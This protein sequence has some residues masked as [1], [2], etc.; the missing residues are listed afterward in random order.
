MTREEKL[1]IRVECAI[2]EEMDHETSMNVD[3]EEPT[4]SVNVYGSPV[5]AHRQRNEESAVS[6]SYAVP[7]AN[8]NRDCGGS[9]PQ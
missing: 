1:E 5:A 6:T 8:V 2:M 9:Q 3:V 7:L 4:T